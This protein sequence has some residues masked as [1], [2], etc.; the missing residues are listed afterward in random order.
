MYSYWIATGGVMI[1]SR[2]WQK[3]DEGNL[4]G[5]LPGNNC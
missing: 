5:P 2:H 1:S 3:H 4:L